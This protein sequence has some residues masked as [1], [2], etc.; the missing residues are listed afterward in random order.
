M[1]PSRSEFAVKRTKF[2]GIVT[3]VGYRFKVDPKKVEAI[4]SRK[5]LTSA[6]RILL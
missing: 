4:K 5:A 6:K 2:L 1:D 3:C